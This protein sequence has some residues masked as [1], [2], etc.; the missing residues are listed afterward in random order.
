V[1]QE[2]DYRVRVRVAAPRF[3]RHDHENG[4]RYAA[5]VETEF[6]VHV[7]PGQKRV[8]GVAHD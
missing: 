2:G 7:K 3:G 6:T 1:P 8:T 5:P 4:R